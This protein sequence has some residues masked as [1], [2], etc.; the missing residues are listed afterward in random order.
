MAN[1]KPSKPFVKGD[2][3]INRKGK[4]KGFDALREL[5][6][7]I[8]HEI[9][10]DDGKP[11]IING[12]KA[13]I[14]EVVLRQW[15]NSTSPVLQRGAMEVAFGKV[16]DKIEL[17]GI[18]GGRIKIEAYDYNN[19]IAVITGGPGPDSETPS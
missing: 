16:P 4:P 13:T 15:W 17:S 10:Q 5:A 6:Q 11:V 7:S 18:D 1:P 9:A 12:H 14:V 3:R 8:A 19:A 2:P